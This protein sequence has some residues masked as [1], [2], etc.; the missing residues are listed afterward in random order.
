MNAEKFY[1][2]ISKLNK[3]FENRNLEDYLLALY[4]NI[5]EH[6]DKIIS[7]E[8]ILELI[9]K[10]FTSEPYPFQDEWL[11]C[12]SSPD[13]DSIIRKFTNKDITISIDITN[14]TLEPF[15]YSVEVLKFQIAELHK[16]KGKQLEDETKY[17]G[18]TSETGNQWYNF[19]PFMNLEC[20]ARCMV[21]HKMDFEQLDWS[22]IGDLLENGRIYE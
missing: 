13:E 21:D 5:L 3:T 8:L 9:K 14:T 22:F 2:E 20:G 12:T 11:K 18:I 7:Y 16:M 15:D 19:D 4:S 17:F 10:S 1:T 6:K